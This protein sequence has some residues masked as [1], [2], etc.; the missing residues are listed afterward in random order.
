M[1]R[2]LSSYERD[3]ERARAFLESLGVKIRKA[4]VDH[5]LTQEQLSE[6]AG[7]DLNSVDELERGKGGYPTEVVMTAIWALESNAFLI[8]KAE[9]NS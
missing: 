4:R 5:G 6:R 8:R 2:R 1:A 3:P 9:L 7:I